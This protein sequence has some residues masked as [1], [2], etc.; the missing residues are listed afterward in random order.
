MRALRH[1]HMSITVQSRH[2]VKQ[3][4]IQLLFL[5]NKTINGNF[6]TLKVND[7]SVLTSL[8]ITANFTT[9]TVSNNA[10][11]TQAWVTSQAYQPLIAAG[12]FN[13]FTEYS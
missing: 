12:I 5:T 6:F 2:T 1:K 4:Q 8:L 10:V 7:V 13:C 11:A 9:L 3:C